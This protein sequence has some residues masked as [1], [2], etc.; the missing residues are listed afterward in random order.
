MCTSKVQPLVTNRLVMTWISLHPPKENTSTLKKLAYVAIAIVILTTVIVYI[1]AGLVFVW[2]FKSID[3][4]K[5]L[6]VFTIAVY[7]TDLLIGIMVMYF[8]RYKTKAMFDHLSEIY[9]K[10]NQHI[11]AYH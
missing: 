7:A 5:C 4:R 9:R 11:L 8:S 3:L 6:L 1:L 2:K 10:S